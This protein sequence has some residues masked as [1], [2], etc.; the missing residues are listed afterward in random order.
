M[1]PKKNKPG[2]P[3][4]SHTPKPVKVATT[5]RFFPE[6]REWLREKEAQGRSISGVVNA[7]VEAEMKREARGK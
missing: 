1:M 6:I 4:G 5:V 3:K 7:A 2:R